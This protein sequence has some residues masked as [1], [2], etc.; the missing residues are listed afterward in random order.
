MA[1]T[2]VIVDVVM[3]VLIEGE[4]GIRI[5]EYLIRSFDGGQ[6]NGKFWGLLVFC[7]GNADTKLT[8]SYTKATP[9]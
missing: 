9:V 6:R 3:K 7:F 4:V 5:T 2:L 8:V 1:G